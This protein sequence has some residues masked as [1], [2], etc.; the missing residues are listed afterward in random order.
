MM[1]LLLC[2]SAKI[3]EYFNQG[4]YILSLSLG[5]SS[6][7]VK[8]RNF[9]YFPRVQVLWKR[10][11]ETVPNFHTKKL[12]EITAFFVS[13]VFFQIIFIQNIAMDF[14]QTSF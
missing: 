4:F 11:V 7:C 12:G 6:R 2:N 13:V 3:D 9:T 10:T 8:Y 14:I 1:V 5:S